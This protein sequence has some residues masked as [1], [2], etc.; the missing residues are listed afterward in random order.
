MLMYLFIQIND[1]APMGLRYHVVHLTRAVPGAY[2]LRTYGA[3][4]L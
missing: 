4:L 1:F 2:D 3:L